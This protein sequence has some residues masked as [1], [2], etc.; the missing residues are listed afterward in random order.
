ME[1]YIY[2]KDLY[3]QNGLKESNFEDR[4]KNAK[5]Q[6]DWEIILAGY[7]IENNINLSKDKTNLDFLAKYKDKNFYIEATAPTEG[8]NN[9]K[10]IDVPCNND[11][12][13]DGIRDDNKI[14]LRFT[15]CIQDK[16]KQINTKNLDNKG[17]VIL[18]ING[19][20]C[21]KNWEIPDYF[22]MNFPFIV[23]CA[24][25]LGNLC[26]NRDGKLTFD[27]STIYKKG[28]KN[29]HIPAIF[30][31]QNTPI[32]GIIYSEITQNKI[33]QY[34]ISKKD[35]LYIQNPLKTDFRDTFSEIMNIYEYESKGTKICLKGVNFN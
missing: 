33:L 4:Y 13:E 22:S 6:T 12:F 30:P 31:N 28:E 9:N 8:N 35:F 7:L 27:C 21:V 2:Y 1:K 16:I 15:S 18:A 25:G 17:N 5:F 14:F 10:V 20:Q 11:N 29:L 23:R 24:F 26:I 3:F 19:K 34:G 32:S